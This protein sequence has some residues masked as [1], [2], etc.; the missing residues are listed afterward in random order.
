MKRLLG[1]Y[2]NLL[3][4]YK[5][6]VQIVSGGILWFSGDCLSQWI[7]HRSSSGSTQYHS[8]ND[9]PTSANTATS[10]DRKDLNTIKDDRSVAELTGWFDWERAGKMTLYGMCFSAP[11]YTLWYTFLDAWSHRI[12]A[13]RHTPFVSWHRFHASFAVIVFRPSVFQPRLL[14]LLL[15][16]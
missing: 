14:H 12:F 8:T 10:I 4:R 7:S 15:L 5:Y 1:I 3:H 9:Q 16:A 13:P 11:L 6:P 2:N